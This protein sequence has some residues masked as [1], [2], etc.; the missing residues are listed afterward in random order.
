MITTSETTKA[1]GGALLKFQGYVSG[2]KRDGKNPHFKSRYATLE[3]VFDTARP[4]LQD[5]GI[6]VVQ[7]PCSIVEGSLEITTRLI[8]AESGEWMQSTMHMPLGKRDPQGAG[9]ATTYGLRYS[10]MAML[11]LP[12]TDD[13]DGNY[14]SLP[15]RQQSEVLPSDA[16]YPKYE[17]PPRRKSGLP[18]Y[19]WRADGSKTSFQL[20]KEQSWEAVKAELDQDLVDCH[21]LKQLEDIKTIYRGFATERH[22]NRS[23][24]GLLKEQFDAHE[25]S[26]MEAMEAAELAEVPLKTA[27]KQ[28]IK[29]DRD[30]A[31]TGP[32]TS[33]AN[34]ILAG[35]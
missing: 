18:D 14:A 4:G 28:S 25:K 13:D 29:H 11:G 2:V 30:D 3:N 27:L 16:D 22:W 24:F 8:H 12:P 15:T 1:I 20:G 31:R 5:V 23:F 10:L 26:I 17:D 32:R 35:G 7:A 33:P 19:G 34:T 6:A 9:S 21:S